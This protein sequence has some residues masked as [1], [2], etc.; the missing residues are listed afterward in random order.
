MQLNRQWLLHHRPEGLIGEADFEYRESPLGPLADGEARVRVLW[1]SFDPAQRGWIN[2]APGYVPPV[3]IGEAMR[4]GAVGQI[5]ESRRKDYEPGDFV[6]GTMSWQDYVTLPAA[7]S[8]SLDAIYPVRKIDAAVPLTHY[9]GVL[10]I[11][12]ITAWVGMIDV[13][14]L[15]AGDTVVIS[16]AAGA[17]GSVA[18]QIAKIQG[19]R[20]IGIAGG[21]DKCGFLVERCGFDAAIDYRNER[22]SRRLRELAPKGAD[23]CF[24]N[25]GGDSLDAMLLN[26]AMRARVVICGGISGGYG[27]KTPPGP[28]HYMQLVVK[29]ARMEGFLVLNYRHRYAE[30]QRALRDWVASGRLHVAE[31][32]VVG[33]EHAPATLR[34]LFEG[35]NVGKQLLK[36]A[37]PPLPAR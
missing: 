8:A 23:L 22:V 21:P 11:T 14:Q 35:G 27:M 36:V 20:V 25:V 5:V 9:L 12:G 10:G 19:A 37:D 33:L 24:D 30:A 29:S 13:G 15:K 7:A 34:R 6:Q 31:D 18:G 28:K 26:L 16:G 32:I 1:L 17:T 2:D 4:A 3:Q